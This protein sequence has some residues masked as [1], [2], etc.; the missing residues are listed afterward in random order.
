MRSENNQQKIIVSLIGD[1]LIN[2]KLVNGLNKLG[3]ESDKYSLNLMNTIFELLEVDDL[4]EN[5]YLYEFYFEL[6]NQVV[7]NDFSNLTIDEQAEEIYK[8]LLLKIKAVKA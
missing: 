2:T 6:T 8:E 1:D 5:E 4:A 7:E 3:L